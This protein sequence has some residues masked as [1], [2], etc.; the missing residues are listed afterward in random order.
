M[1][2]GAADPQ[3][4]WTSQAVITTK[5]LG[6][7]RELRSNNEFIKPGLPII[8]SQVIAIDEWLS[9]KLLYP[10]NPPCLQSVKELFFFLFILIS[11]FGVIQS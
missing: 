6:I 4:Q 9:N 1:Y 7:S 11:E 2:G 5:C 10:Y 8:V 3:L